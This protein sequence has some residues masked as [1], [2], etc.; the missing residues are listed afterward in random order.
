MSVHGAVSIHVYG[1]NRLA[2]VQERTRLL[3]RLDFL[4]SL[5]VDVFRIADSLR[6][7]NVP[8]AEERKIRDSAVARLEKMA[9]NVL[10][11]IRAAANPE[12]PFSAT[13]RQWIKN[14]VTNLPW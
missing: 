1:L 6:A 8:D 5:V 12:A 4:A 10:A 7:I 9:G 3:R 14:F 11:D 13:A 2:L